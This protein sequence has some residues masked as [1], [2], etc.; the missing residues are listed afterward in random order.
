MQAYFS[1]TNVRNVPDH[2]QQFVASGSN[3]AD[4]QLFFIT[5]YVKSI[6]KL[7][8][9]DSGIT[10]EGLEFLK[11]LESVVYLDLGGAPL[12]DSNLD[13]ITHFVDLE[14]LYLKNTGVSVEGLYR[15]LCTFPKLTTLI[16]N[17][18][19]GDGKVEE[20]WR[21]EFPGC[22]LVLSC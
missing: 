12:S 7:I 1:T 8:L 2:L 4:E 20:R 3:D 21:G 13:C 17:I 10:R 18:G 19:E 15:L 22:E 6:S 16:A 14:F 11:K 9:R 5:N